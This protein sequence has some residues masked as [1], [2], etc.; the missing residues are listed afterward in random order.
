MVKCLATN[1]KDPL[2]VQLADAILQ[3]VKEGEFKGGAGSR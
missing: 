1:S 3:A 2:Y